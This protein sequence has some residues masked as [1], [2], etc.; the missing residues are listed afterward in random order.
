MSRNQFCTVFSE[1]ALFLK[2][3]SI[4]PWISGGRF[5]CRN[6]NFMIVRMS[7]FENDSSML[8]K[9]T[10]N[11]IWIRCTAPFIERPRPQCF[12]HWLKKDGTLL[13]SS[14]SQI[15]AQ[16]LHFLPPKRTF[17]MHSQHQI[18]FLI[19]LNEFDRETTVNLI[20]AVSEFW[21]WCIL[22]HTRLQMDESLMP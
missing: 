11:E 10:E 13:S 20:F 14:F 6:K 9:E 1:G 17:R 5:P 16:E 12:A 22:S 7:C 18:L 3:P 8:A 19:K 2:T 21:N 15:A 4:S